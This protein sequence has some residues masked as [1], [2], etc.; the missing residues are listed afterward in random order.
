MI[1][2]IAA[3]GGALLLL[4]ACA[5]SRPPRTAPAS[6]VAS[7]RPEPPAQ[8]HGGKSADRDE[9]GARDYQK[10]VGEP[11]SKIPV[12]V[13]PA[14]QRV[15]CTTCP[16]T[17]DYAPRRLDFFFDAETGLIREVKCG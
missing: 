8:H 13:N 11:R 12:P 6:P 1:R 4:A 14:L 5:D 9:C 10:L 17:M 16:V 15:A 2:T 3:L 7:P